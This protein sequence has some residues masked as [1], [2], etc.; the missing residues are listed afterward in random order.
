VPFVNR[1]RELTL[2]LLG[3]L[4]GLVSAAILHLGPFKQLGLFLRWQALLAI[5]ISSALVVW[6][7][8][9]RILTTEKWGAVIAAVRI[10]AVNVVLFLLMLSTL[11][12]FTDRGPAD[13]VWGTFGGI[14]FFGLW[15]AIIISPLLALLAVASHF[16]IAAVGRALG[17]SY[18]GTN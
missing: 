4:C 1:L 9:K 8:R 3:C 13:T 15:S 18:A 10:V 7:F 6:I 14:L 11:V 17:I 12:F 2:P 16:L 5:G